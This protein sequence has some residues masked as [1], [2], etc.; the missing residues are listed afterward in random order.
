M[1]RGLIAGAAAI[2]GLVFMLDGSVHGGKDPVSIKVVMKK[3][4][5]KGG[6]CG[7]VAKGEASADEKKE[8]E[9]AD[10]EHRSDALAIL[11]PFSAQRGAKEDRAT[12]KGKL[13]CLKSGRGIEPEGSRG[14]KGERKPE[15]KQGVTGSDLATGFVRGTFPAG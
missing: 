8:R 12:R 1:K 6:L 4:M 13:L 2:F 15:G 14:P 9:V 7:K 10:P 5:G 11:K 3:A